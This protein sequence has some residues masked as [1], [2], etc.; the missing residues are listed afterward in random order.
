M[1][2]YHGTLEVVVYDPRPDVGGA[3]D[4]AGIAEPLGDRIDGF[5]HVLVR[6]LRFRYGSQLGEFDGRLLIRTSVLRQILKPEAVVCGR[7]A[8]RTPL[9]GRPVYLGVVPAAHTPTQKASEERYEDSGH[10]GNEA[11]N[12]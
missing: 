8:F 11:D 5:E 12:A 3:G 10:G 7:Q 6:V 1:V 4:L 9:S 2:G